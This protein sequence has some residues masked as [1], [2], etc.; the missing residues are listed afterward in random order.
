MAGIAGPAGKLN[1]LA[2]E[3]V[4]P[5]GMTS[6]ELVLYLH[7]ASAIIW[8]GA[9][10]LTIVAQER[11][12]RSGDTAQ[13][14]RSFHDESWLAPRL[15]IPA[16][17]STL[18][19]GTLLVILG[20]WGFT[21]GWILVGLGGFATTFVTG[22][23]FLKPVGERIADALGQDATMDSGVTSRLKKRLLVGRMDMAVLFTV[24]FDMAVK[25]RGKELLLLLAVAV[26]LTSIAVF[27]AGAS[28]P[29]RAT[30]A[31]APFSRSG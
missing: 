1:A 2:Y 7:I 26:I 17:L 24:V 30:G 14:L 6:Y 10:F 11:A 28:R 9:G 27:A 12:Y 13:I 22:I 20:D 3:A 23:A 25:P 29:G 8:L 21:T 5:A 18:V 16:A 31:P 15:F 4:G 19:L